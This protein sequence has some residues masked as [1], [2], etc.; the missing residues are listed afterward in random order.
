MF[1][2]IKRYIHKIKRHRRNKRLSKFAD[3]MFEASNRVW[4]KI[5][6]HPLV[7]EIINFR[8]HDSVTLRNLVP[9]Y[10]ISDYHRIFLIGVDYV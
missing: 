6:I 9:D 10:L 5:G 3:A 2:K 4:Y 1:E 8:H 7:Y